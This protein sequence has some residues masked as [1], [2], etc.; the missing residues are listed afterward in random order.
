MG[1]LA[2]DPD[3]IRYL[4]HHLVAA[5]DDLRTV[6]SSDAAATYAMRS[7]AAIRTEIELVWLPLITRIL[8]NTALTREWWFSVGVSDSLQNALINV[9]A[10]GYGWTVQRDPL[11]DDAST[12][13]PEEARALGAI[14]NTADLLALAQDRD[15]L[16][17]LAQQLQVIGR[18]PTL[19][20]EFLAN[21]NSWQKVTYVLGLEYANT[22]RP[23]IE[24]VFDGL[25]KVWANTLPDGALTAGTSASLDALL[26][27]IDDADPYV[28]ALMLRSL[29]PDAMTVATLASEL[30]TRWLSLKDDPS[31]ATPIDLLVGPGSNAADLLLPLLLDDP[32][33]CVW[34]TEF[35]AHHPA[36][37]FE[38]LNDPDSAYQ[39]VLI[40]TDPAHTTNAVAGRA[41]LAILDYFRVDPYL[42]PGFD[43]DGHP[44]DYGMFL[45]DL[46]APWLLQFTMSNEDWDSS[47]GEKAALLRVALH[48]EQAMQQLINDAERIHAG[49]VESLSTNGIAAA[50]QVGALLNL[51]LQLSVNERVADEAASTDNRFNLLWSVVG[52]ASSFLPGGPAVGIASGFTQRALRSKLNEYLDQPDPT[53]AR[54]SAE[55]AMDVALALAGAD[56]IARLHQQWITDGV[57]AASHRPPPTVDIT[58]ES[59]C[60]SAE[61]HDAFNEWLGH[62][63]DGPNGELGRQA[64]DLLAAFVGSSQ[65][66]S[67]CAEIAG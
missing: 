40:G 48:D 35:A 54:R 67:N 17:W 65:A 46:V 63:P 60:P 7:L 38:T 28:Q 16:R 13:T 32:A 41:V 9:M 56:A 6:R 52:V 66:Q 4:K 12:V 47:P 23:D 26:P 27:P 37:L 33:S 8:D 29:H 49:F 58:N 44:G 55:R 22:E 43:N 31:A 59:S 61:F 50:N 10:D 62:L 39:V 34:F 45:G 30:L 53:G 25:M 2:Y 18:D 15:Q 42:R 19:S 3:R 57:I 20:A 14:L 24:A 5:V 64:G 11:N 51:L 36:I 1:L 21:F